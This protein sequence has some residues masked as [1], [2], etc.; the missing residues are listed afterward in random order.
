MKDSR[1]GEPDHRPTRLTALL[2]G[3]VLA[4]GIGGCGE[5]STGSPKP[6][7][8]ISYALVAGSTIAFTGPTGG[9][10]TEI[11]TATFDVIPHE[12]MGAPNVEFDYDIVR[13]R[14]RS[15]S[16]LVTARSGR[17]TATTVLFPPLAFDADAE[18]DGSRVMLSGRSSDSSYTR[19]GRPP[20]FEGVTIEGAG[21]TL[22]ISAF[23]PDAPPF[24]Y[25]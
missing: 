15:E 11:L 13:L 3:L 1:S 24:A 21:Y 23:S 25:N 22:I 6:R 4:A 20:L 12:G 19:I 9:R 17:I 2:V 14:F 8:R 16:V 18:I 7:T 10:E 5:E